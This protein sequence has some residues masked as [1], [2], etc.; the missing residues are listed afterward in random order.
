MMMSAKQIALVLKEAFLAFPNEDG[1]RLGFYSRR[2]KPL[3]AYFI[4]RSR[5]ILHTTTWV[6]GSIGG[7][8]WGV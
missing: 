7:E 3:G 2:A 6:V 5:A 8:R 1:D 4:V